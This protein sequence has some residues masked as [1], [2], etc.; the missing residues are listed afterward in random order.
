MSGRAIGL[1]MSWDGCPLVQLE[2]RYQ[3]HVANFI[4][5]LQFRSAARRAPVR[6]FVLKILLPHTHPVHLIPH[7]LSNGMNN[8]GRTL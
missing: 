8:A 4:K 2:R 3:V 6:R 7:K 5:Y 1:E